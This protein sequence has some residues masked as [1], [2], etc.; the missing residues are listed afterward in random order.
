MKTAIFI[1]KSC[2]QWVDEAGKTHEPL[3]KGNVEIKVPDFFERNKFKALLMSAVTTSGETDVSTI[4]SAS[5]KVDVQRMMD[6]VA[7]LV[8]ESIPFYKKVDLQNITSGE[9][10]SSFESLSC[11]KDADSIVQEIAQEIANGFTISKN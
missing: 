1:P 6:K 11:D 8:R 9:S 5:N 2:T 10:H 3:F 7:E 4:K